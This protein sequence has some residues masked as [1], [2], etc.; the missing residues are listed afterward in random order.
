MKV[1]MIGQKG[2]PAIHGGVER[3]VEELA[4]RLAARGHEVVVYTRPHFTSRDMKHYRRVQLVSLPTIKTK[5]LDAISHTIFSTI[6]AVRHGADIIHYHGVGPSLVAF[7]PKLMRSKAKVITTFHC[8]D[9][10][11]KKWGFVARQALRHGEW[12]AVNL[13]DQTIVVSKTLQKYVANVF[14][15]NVP[16]IPNGI[17]PQPQRPRAMT[18]TLKRFGLKPNEY[19]VSVSRLIAHKGIHHL[20]SAFRRTDT[21]MKLVIVGDGVFTDEYVQYLHQLAE[22]DPRI[23]FTGFQ[24]GQ[25]LRDL[26]RNAALYV[27]PS[28]AEGLPI[29]LLEAASYGV[30]IIASDIPENREVIYAERMPIGTTFATGDDEDLQRVL[31]DALRRPAQTQQMAERARKIVNTHFNWEDVTNKTEAVYR[32]LMNSTRRVPIQDHSSQRTEWVTVATRG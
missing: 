28:E 9:R 31:G 2:I 25:P 32:R 24:N 10:K 8:V 6:H 13:P 30:G 4:V 21:K 1:A 27:L 26:F 16:Y 19:I 5:H 11:H 29:A 15:K 18:T 23:I 14:G 20:I 3:H 22:D 17:E 7:I 12:S